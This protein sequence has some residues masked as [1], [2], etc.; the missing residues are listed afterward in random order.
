[1]RTSIV[2]PQWVGA[3]SCQE[4]LRADRCRFA[5]LR[6]FEQRWSKHRRDV[7]NLN[8][9]IQVAVTAGSASV[10]AAAGEYRT[11]GAV[12][13]EI[14]DTVDGEQIGKP[15]ARPIDAALDRA[16]G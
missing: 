2:T 6:N 14:V 12:G 3:S 11:G 5:V 16:D 10:A 9:R 7:D 4:V 13:A 15:G 8:N 1:M